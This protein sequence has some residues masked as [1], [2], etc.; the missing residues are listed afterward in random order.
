MRKSVEKCQTYPKMWT[1]LPSIL[2]IFAFKKSFMSIL[3][4]QKAL[5]KNRIFATNKP[6]TISQNIITI[7]DKNIAS[8][9]NAVSCRSLLRD[10]N[11]C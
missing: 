9:L 8:I 3:C 10:D 11:E 1:I 4:C 2:D 7:I 5:K 6:L